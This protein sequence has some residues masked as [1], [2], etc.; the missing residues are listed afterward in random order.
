MF[1][2]KKYVQFDCVGRVGG[3]DSGARNSKDHILFWVNFNTCDLIAELQHLLHLNNFL[4]AFLDKLKGISI[5]FSH[6][7]PFSWPTSEAYLCCFDR[8]VLRLRLW[9][10]CLIQSIDLIPRKFIQID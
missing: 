3:Y 10:D 5:T 2:N 4:P 9:F 1:S 7:N 6:E 8:I